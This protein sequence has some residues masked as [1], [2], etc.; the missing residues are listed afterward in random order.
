VVGPDEAALIPAAAPNAS[1]VA[2]TAAN[3]TAMVRFM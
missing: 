1:V 3:G 2:T